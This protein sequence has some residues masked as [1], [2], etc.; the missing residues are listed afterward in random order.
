MRL[1]PDWGEWG[2]TNIKGLNMA[3]SEEIKQRRVLEVFCNL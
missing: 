1:E 2:T 3:L